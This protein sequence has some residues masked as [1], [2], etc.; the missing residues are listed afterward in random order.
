MTTFG[1]RVAVASL[2]LLCGTAAA[3][4]QTG[5]T[6][7]SVPFAFT[8][9]TKTLPRDSY[10]ISRLTGQNGAFLIRGERDGV[11][12]LSQP[13][14]VTDRAAEPVLVF[15]RYGERYFLREARL[16]D[17]LAF[18][19]PKTRAEVDAEERLAQHAQP[20]VVVVRALAQ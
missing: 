15:H 9:G 3:S 10:R 16:A 19:L 18:R 14:V 17:R 6:V 7:S 13:D 2:T 5:E 4:A 20:E 8:A 12:I 1:W 11:V